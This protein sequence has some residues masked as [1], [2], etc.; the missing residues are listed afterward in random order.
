PRDRECVAELLASRAGKVWQNAQFDL[1][2]L[3]RAGFD[4]VG[5]QHDLMLLYHATEPLIAGKGESGAKQTQKSL[6]F[7]A[8]VYTDEPWYKDYAFQ[9]EEARWAL[10]ATDA[11]VTLEV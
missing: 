11:R 8:S 9:S 2:I 1:T 5:E 7:L 3:R 6:R 10:C 4:V